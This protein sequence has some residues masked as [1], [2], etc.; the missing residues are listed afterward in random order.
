MNFRRVRP[1]FLQIASLCAGLLL[2]LS[3]GPLGAQEPPAERLPVAGITTVYYQN[4]HSDV[5][6]SRLFQTHNLDFMGRVSPLELASLYVDQFPQQDRS[7]E[8]AAKYGF[9]LYDNRRDPLTLGTDKLAVR[10]VFVIAEHGEYPTSELGSIQYPKRKWL[11]EV[12]DV[13]R[14]TGQVV[15]VF[16]D[17]HLADTTEDVLWIYN[18]AQELG[19]PMMAGSS[20]PSLWRYPPTNVPQGAQLKQIVSVSY[21]LLDVYGFHALEMMQCLAEQ[22]AGGETGVAAVQMLTGEA[23]WS[24]AEQGVY[25]PELL[26]AALARMQRQPPADK[27]LRELVAEPVLWVIDYRDGLRSCVFTLNG[28]VG[29]FA[30]AW[31]LADGT[32]DSTLF[33][34]QEAR[35]VQ[36]FSFLL[37][38]IEQMMLTGEPAWPVERTVF[39]SCLLD[40]LLVSHAQGDTRLETPELHLEYQSHW[41]WQEPPPPP[42]DRPF[43]QQ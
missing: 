23:V 35:P 13:F 18:T 26:Q 36:H 7:R 11:G 21:H 34:T 24:A 29:E 8:Y 27:T 33:F 28:A 1:L 12:F 9:T 32:L 6:L 15:P 38:G 31:R 41:R 2:A 4:S 5:L 22:R 37:T 17:K 25:D 40:R 3:A 16:C 19:V 42:P 30:S 43:D 10:G 14:E 39:T 20:L